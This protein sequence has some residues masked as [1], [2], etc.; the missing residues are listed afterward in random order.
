MTDSDKRD[1][2][3]GLLGTAVAVT[4]WGTS[5]VVVKAIHMDAIAIGFWRFLLYSLVLT[6]WMRA[7]GATV[8][9]RVLKYSAGGGICL[10][11]DVILF[12][13][14]VKV[15]NIVNAT[16]IGALQPLVVSVFAARLFGERIRGRNIIAALVAIVG[17]VVIVVESS[18]TP[19]WNG[20]GDLA[21]V[22]ALFSWS[23]YFVFSKRSKDHLTSMQYTVGT[24]IWTAM[25]CLPAGFIFGQDMSFP[26]ATDWLPLIGL[27]FGAGILGHAVMNWSLVRVPLWLGS[28]FT[29]LIPVVSSITAWT[30]LD[31]PLT[32]IQ[33]T[34]MAVV[35]GALA[36]VVAGSSDPVPVTA[37]QTPADLP[38]RSR[39]S[40]RR[41][42]RGHRDADR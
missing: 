41:V 34:A 39:R 17:V 40:G 18:G 13:T 12:F 16:T 15:T 32:A 35:V 11:L 37:P 22:G 29:L 7:R 33:V 6:A 38:D 30:F 28:M 25:I 24:A 8:D 21:A 20:A 26:S 42:E 1:L 2:Q 19:E 3:L 36:A 4:A 5:G 10:G 27:A 14:A 23:G 31:E 9:L